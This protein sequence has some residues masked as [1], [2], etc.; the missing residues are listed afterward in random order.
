MGWEWLLILGYIALYSVQNGKEYV[1]NT[2]RF[3]NFSLEAVTF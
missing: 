3:G 1:I 2:E